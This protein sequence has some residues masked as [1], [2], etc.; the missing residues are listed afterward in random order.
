MLLR[1]LKNISF[2]SRFSL[3]GLLFL[4]NGCTDIKK[5]IVHDYPKQKA[6]VFDNKITIK[7]TLSKKNAKA[8]SY[9]L[10]NY[11]DDS[12]KA[13]RVRQFG[14]FNNL[15]QPITY[16]PERIGRSIQYMESFLASRG[17]HHPN[18]NLIAK[19]DTTKNEYRV[20][21]NMIVQL[22]KK[23]FIDTVTY[24]LNNPKL[25]AIANASKEMAYV[26][27]GMAY[28]NESINQELD[29]LVTLFRSK[30][31]YYFTKEKIFAEVDT[32]NQSLMTLNLDP[33]AQVNQVQDA[34]KK[35]Q[36]NPTW[37]I[38]F[39]LRNVNES[40][41]KAYPIGAQIYYSD[42]SLAD[43]PDSIM[44]HGM[45]NRI[46]LGD[47]V[48]QYNKPK[49]NAKLF[50]EQSVIQKGELFNEPLFYQDLN[51]LSGLGAWQQ[52][53]ARTEIK[54][55]SVQLHYFL[56]PALRRNF[57]ADLE[58]SRNTAQLG[59]GNLLGIA[60]SFTYRDRN[61]LKKSI[62]SISNVRTGV[63]LDLNNTNLTQTLLVNVG[64]SFSFPSLLVPF[65]PV[66]KSINSTVK[67]NFS[68]NGSYINRL[69]Y[70][71]LKSFTTS[72]GYEWKKNKLGVEDII[73]Y[74]PINLE[75]YQ[76][77]K[78]A[79]L[80]S[81]LIL[82]PFLRSSF[83]NGNVISQTLSYV[84][85]GPSRK[86]GN[87]INYFRIGIEEAG[88][89]LGLSKNIQKNIYQYIKAEIEIRKLIKYEN[90]ELAWRFMGG[91]GNNYSSNTNLAGQLPFF[92]QF[93]AG[94]PYSMRAWGLR[95]LGLGSSRF[96][97]TSR[98][99]QNFD[100]F[101][102]FQLETN[103]EYRFNI[104]QLGSYKIASALF[105]DIGNIWNIRDS[106]QDPNAGFKLDRLY[107]DLAVGVGTGLRLDFNYFLIR[108]DYAL[109]MKD[110]TRT[111]N[112]GWLDI[113]NFKWSEV[114]PNG[115]KVN[116]FAWQFGIGLP[117]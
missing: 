81:L 102:D 1:K 14:V 56:V 49:F 57:S 68:L 33:L 21:L 13:K 85:S 112:N 28:S 104:L 99:N 61:V 31:Y 100:R 45:L 58:G 9:E 43:N 91:W 38:N 83:N 42:L 63:E 2:F 93:T 11:W 40:I 72:W 108:I 80:D 41:T 16:Q 95:Q 25:Q 51:N 66:K 54:K 53:D 103:L 107:Q 50:K 34:N 64:Q 97:D 47:I 74:K 15:V 36:G 23:T 101:G 17:Y 84:H 96:Y 44:K 117:F 37:K 27:K 30:G 52:I 48:H 79:K 98:S 76:L 46:Q 113:N 19:T 73:I 26:K 116:N 65:V 105:T 10:S 115:T 77:N 12:L 111:Y 92:K 67:S 8:L 7:G 32:I 24:Q 4:I 35:E 94:G 86:H 22:N 69:N 20:Y 3:L 55:D 18:L 110:P 88:G 71:Q 60:T 62:Q 6:F 106:E 90:S 5:A 29:R 78:Y 109:K 70:Y 82:N 89:L 87:Q 59:A 75:L 114:K 39:Q